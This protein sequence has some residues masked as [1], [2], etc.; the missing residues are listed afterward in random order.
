MYATVWL[1]GLP[2]YI[3]PSNFINKCII[4]IFNN[5]LG[6]LMDGCHKFYIV[7]SL[8]LQIPRGNV[9]SILVYQH[10]F[11]SSYRMTPSTYDRQESVVRT[12]MTKIL[13]NTFQLTRARTPLLPTPRPDKK[14]GG[15]GIGPATLPC[16]NHIHNG[17]D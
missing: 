2:K 11:D 15:L 14:E 6:P 5:N 16:K 10:V 13:Y 12:Q 9:L 8:F 17:N 3:L 1:S 4:L 7:H